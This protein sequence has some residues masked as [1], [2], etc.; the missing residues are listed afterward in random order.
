MTV[1]RGNGLLSLANLYAR[2]WGI[3]RTQKPL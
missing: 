3:E 1:D 2:R